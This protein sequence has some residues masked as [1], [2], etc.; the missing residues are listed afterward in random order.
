MCRFSWNLG[1]SASWKLQG[2]SRPVMGLFY[3][4]FRPKDYPE[5]KGFCVDLLCLSSRFV[6]RCTGGP[7]CDVTPDRFSGTRK[8]RRLQYVSALRHKSSFRSVIKRS[9][10]I[11]RNWWWQS[12][13]IIERLRPLEWSTK[14]YTFAH[15][16]V[17]HAAWKVESHVSLNNG[18]TFWEMRL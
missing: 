8:T 12:I 10:K 17:Y 4:C 18:D 7:R 15:E 14:H 6:F 9:D 2:L 3:L 13:G 1:A 5:Q 11:E 16:P